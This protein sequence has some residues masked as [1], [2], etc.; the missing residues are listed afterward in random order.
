MLESESDQVEFVYRLTLFIICADTHMQIRLI[1][2]SYTD[3][4]SMHYWVSM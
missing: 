1:I 4:N 3:L 2:M